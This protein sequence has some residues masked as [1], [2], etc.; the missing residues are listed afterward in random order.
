V[1]EAAIQTGMRRGELLSLQWAQVIGMTIDDTTPTPTPTIRWAARAEISLPW[2]K[3]KTK[4]DRRIPISTRLRAILEMR[5]F[6]PDG[7]PLPATAFVFGNAIGQRV[8]DVG[9]AFDTA[10][11]KAHGHT[12]KFTKTGGLTRESR[13][14]LK[15]ID[16]HFHDLRREAGSRWVEGGVPLHTVRDWLGHTSIAQTSTYL[17]GTLQTQHD[18]MAA[19]EAR[20]R[21]RAGRTGT[22]DQYGD[23]VSDTCQP[24]RDR[25]AKTTTNGNRASQK[26]Q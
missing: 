25:G 7:T 6:D 17:A 1:V 3:T 14:T 26:T 22:A 8:V 21:G 2:T 9:R 5:R 4:K 11:L 19:F 23:S 13:A 18:A 24:G 10:V 20:T 12:P 16:L 15:A